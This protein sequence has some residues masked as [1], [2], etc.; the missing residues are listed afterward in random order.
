MK[1]VQ[2]NPKS[3]PNVIGSH[4]QMS[5]LK[6]GNDINRLTVML[7]E[8]V[9]NSWD[10]R[11]SDE[12][13]VGF[14]LRAYKLDDDN[15]SALNSMIGNTDYGWN[16]YKAIR[17]RERTYEITDTETCGLSGP[18]GFGN[19][20]GDSQERYLKF[21]YEVGNS[22]QKSGAGGSF[23]YGKT[24]LYRL[25]ETGTCAV[26]TKIKN[27]DGKA[28]YRF[29]IKCIDRIGKI[30]PQNPGVFWWGNKKVSPDDDE[31]GSWVEPVFD[32]EANKAWELLGGQKFGD[33]ETGTKILIFNPSLVNDPEKS[34][35]V[36]IEDWNLVLASRAVVHFFW[37]KWPDQNSGGINFEIINDYE[38]KNEII[39]VDDPRK[40]S[41][42]KHLIRCLSECKSNTNEK[43]DD[44]YRRL[45]ECHKPKE[46]LGNFVAQPLNSTDIDEKYYRYFQTKDSHIALMRNVEFV[47]DYYTPRVSRGLFDEEDSKTIIFGVFRSLDNHLVQRGNDYEDLIDL[48]EVYRTAE[49]QTHGSWSPSNAE[50]L[51]P[52]CKSYVSVTKKRID[53]SVRD[54]VK[55][56]SPNE[57]HQKVE[58]QAGFMGFLGQYIDGARGGGQPDFPRPNGGSGGGRR[59]KK[60]IDILN[61][62]EHQNGNGR[63]L[64]LHCS[65]ETSTPD[66]K[67]DIFPVCSDEDGR[68]SITSDRRFNISLPVKIT[69]AYVSGDKHRALV[70][71]DGMITI[72]PG[73]EKADM[74]LTV[75]VIGDCRFTLKA[76]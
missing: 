8:A 6:D 34:A 62:E 11:L 26:Y 31:L 14:S 17:N 33:D 56:L 61:V 45:I 25:S 76:K 63:Y 12:K 58:A 16:L 2:F 67:I 42:Y 40:V 68:F 60:N 1:L 37:A 65:L 22:Q 24:S 48:N 29:I 71:D 75:K 46:K 73:A 27:D 23:G 50:E 55:S 59:V 15:L 54:I 20:K 3:G 47:V 70:V 28:E 32:E 64:K 36:D 74:K 35:F 18:V 38:N 53:S 13:G 69:K 66:E 30:G 9:Q 72:I 10:A 44:S 4:G 7:R 52:W 49:N 41:P 21:V 19:R 39:E 5:L 43:A 57:E 51:G